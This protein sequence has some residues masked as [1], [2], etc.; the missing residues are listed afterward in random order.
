MQGGGVY[1]RQPDGEIRT[2]VPKRRVVGGIALHADGGVVI[3]GRDICHVRDGESRVLFERPEGA[4]SF[5]DLFTDREGRI[6]TGTARANPFDAGTQAT[7]GEAYRVAG[8]GE[9]ELLYGEVGLTNGIGFS[10]DGRLLYHAD[11]MSRHIIVHDVA[12]DGSLSGRRALSA[13]PQ[14]DGLAVDVDG[15][16]WVASYG[17]GCVVRVTPDDRRDQTI[18]V[19]AKSVTSV[20]FGHADPTEMYIVSADNTDDPARGG[21]IFRTRA[22]VAGLVPP[23]ARV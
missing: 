5:N 3:S 20:C 8:P 6:I 19:P 18:D 16:L 17:E 9:G 11:T 12:E 7:P 2:V 21:S 10:P 1:Y 15:C 4:L 23:M 22:K 14:P 13:V